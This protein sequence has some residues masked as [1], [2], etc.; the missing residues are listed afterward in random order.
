MESRF[1]V[2][3]YFNVGSALNIYDAMA[4]N[5]GA[6]YVETGLGLLSVSL[7]D[8]LDLVKQSFEKGVEEFA[9]VKPSGS[10][11]KSGICTTALILKPWS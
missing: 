3:P 9:L 7:V 11:I 2:Y 10:M 4:C 1:T 5:S 8:A 6:I